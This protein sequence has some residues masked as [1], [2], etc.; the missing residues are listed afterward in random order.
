MS[1]NFCLTVHLVASFVFILKVP[2]YLRKSS[3]SQLVLHPLSIPHD[4]LNHTA[5]PGLV[6]HCRQSVREVRIMC[7]Q[8]CTV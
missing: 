6:M 8:E 3:I 1:V 2:G 5:I 4:L 7:E